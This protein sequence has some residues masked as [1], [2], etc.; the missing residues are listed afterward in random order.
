MSAAPVERE[1]ER[2]NIIRRTRRK[3]KGKGKGKGIRYYI[4]RTRRKRKG[5]GLATAPDLPTKIIPAKIRRLKHLG[6]FPIDLGIS[7]LEFKIV[8][9]S[10]PLKSRILVWRLAVLC[11]CV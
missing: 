11:V 4:R 8:L 9:E 3:R 1:R 7:P 6:N 5:A 2:E 10:N